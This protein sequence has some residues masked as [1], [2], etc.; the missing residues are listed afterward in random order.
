MSCRT[1]AQMIIKYFRFCTRYVIIEGSVGVSSK[2]MK[3]SFSGDRI[4]AAEPEQGRSHYLTNELRHTEHG[5]SAQQN[6]TSN[7]LQPDKL[8]ISGPAACQP[9]RSH[10]VRETFREALFRRQTHSHFVVQ[11]VSMQIYASV[12]FILDPYL[13]VTV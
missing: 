8:F 10:A 11:V 5:L 7:T 9:I 4:R 6:Q 2:D 12:L 13:G 3:N 1:G